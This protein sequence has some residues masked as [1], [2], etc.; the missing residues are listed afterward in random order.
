MRERTL[1]LAL[2]REELVAEGKP[3]PDVFAVDKKATR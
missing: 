2:S 3:E 1:I